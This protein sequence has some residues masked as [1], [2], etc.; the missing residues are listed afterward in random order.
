MAIPYTYILRNLWARKLT[1][2][3]T[4]VGMALVVYVFATV[5]MLSEGLQQTLVETGGA[6]NVMVTR[7][8]AETEVQSLVDRE[9]ASLIT[10]LPEIAFGQD[11]QRLASKETVVLM[12]LPKRG[13]D[14][15]SNV[16]I[17]GLSERGVTLR[18]QVRLTQG[19][20]FRPGSSEIVAGYKIAQGFS[21]AGLG[22]KL[23]FAQ[24]DWTVVGVFEAGNSGFSSEIWGDVDQL[25][26]SFRRDS[27]SS[28]I[29]KLADS[30]RFEQVAAK[31]DKDQRLTVEAKRETV[32]YAEQSEM[33]R[34][35]IDILGITL[36]VIFSIGA[37]LGAM[38]TMYASV[39]NRTAEIGTLRAIGFQR[40]NI[41]TAFLLESLTLGFIGGL[42]GLAFASLMQFMH[43]STMNWQ[44][45]AE[46]AFGFTLTTGTVAKS[47]GFALTMGLI[48]GFLPS[49]RAARMNI[50]ES[51]RGV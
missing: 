45:F 43:I 48:G 15:P 13:S 37:T 5:L 40:R 44:T 11:G 50:V 36:S 25:M 20:W 51:L 47:L 23:R 19:R 35:F 18:P 34:N 12:V 22:E 3:L 38:I 42:V 39:A 31:L 21:G 49:V 6:D 10:S 26:Q 14:K 33:M 4:A 46:L 24:R 41:L 29:F 1:T 27:Y 16:T 9:E 30:G 32:F 2:F 17:R 8:S 7:Q 28:V